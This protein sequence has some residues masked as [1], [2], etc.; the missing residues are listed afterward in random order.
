MDEM[1]AGDILSDSVI[2]DHNTL[3]STAIS[4]GDVHLIQI[5]KKKNEPCTEK[6]VIAS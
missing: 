5:L 2:W 6:E 1:T 3:P 4:I